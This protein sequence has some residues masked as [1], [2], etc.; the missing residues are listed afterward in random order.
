MMGL[1]MA[2]TER[3]ESRG[4]SC[5]A[6]EITAVD[7]PIMAEDFARARSDG[8]GATTVAAR[9]GIVWSSLRNTSGGGATI[10]S[11]EKVGG[12]SGD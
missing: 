3:D 4:T 5:G 11:F 12:V 2:M 7:R 8:G 1:V 9:P 6:G 10:A